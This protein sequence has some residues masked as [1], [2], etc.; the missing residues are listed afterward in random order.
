MRRDTYN[1]DRPVFSDYLFE[2]WTLR[3]MIWESRN[4]QEMRAK[5]AAMGIQYVLARHDI[6]FDPK[7][8]TL[9]DDD[10][11]KSEN[12]AKLAMAREFLMDPSRTIK[13]DN[14]FSLVKV[15]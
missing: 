13:S 5:T 9:I 12:D 11:P 4:V 6:L 8:S 10:K 7:N 15:F 2:D 3:K 1:L 14:R